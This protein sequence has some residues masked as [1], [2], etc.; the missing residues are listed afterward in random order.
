MKLITITFLLIIV[1]YQLIAQVQPASFKIVGYYSLKAAMSD[2]DTK[3]FKYLTHI[4]LWFFNPDTLGHFTQDLAAITPF[5]R[6]AHKRN[7]KVLFSLGGGSKQSQYHRLLQDDQRA[8]FIE[9]ILSELRKYD[10][11]G[12]DVD[13]EGSDIDENYEKFIV[14]MASKLHANQK[15]ITAAVAVYYKNQ[16]TD[17]ALSAYDF[18]NIMSYDRT[19][20][21]RPDKPGPHATFTHAVED[22]RYFGEERNIPKGKMTLGVPFYGYGYGPSLESK[23]ISMSF[24]KIVNTY[25]D[26]DQ[27]DE[28]L[29][30]DGKLLY[31]NGVPTIQQKTRLAS[32]KASGIM[33]WQV[34]GD[35]TGKKSLLKAIYQAAR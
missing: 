35:A 34:L 6:K 22:L 27:V 20:P 11:D 24:D 5:I 8:G 4:N 7:I 13:L 10:L 15:L 16:F 25:P 17:L 31:Y 18:V 12:I 2:P 19:G 26:A 33:I 30:P 29:L 14:E 3:S 28:W 21:W 9:N 23:A 1:N 32:Q